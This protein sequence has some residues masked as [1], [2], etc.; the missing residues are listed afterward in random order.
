MLGAGAGMTFFAR[1]DDRASSLADARHGQSQSSGR[2]EI[3]LK[4][5][6]VHAA[7]RAGASSRFGGI[8]ASAQY[9]YHTRSN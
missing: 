1:F 9:N 3:S 7:Q 8:I 6:A 2:A 4:G 5:T